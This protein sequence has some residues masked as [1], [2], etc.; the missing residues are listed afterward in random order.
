M[1]ASLSFLEASLLLVPSIIKAPRKQE[2][3][4]ISK[5]GKDIYVKL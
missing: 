5:M 2:N 4:G 3:E 1:P